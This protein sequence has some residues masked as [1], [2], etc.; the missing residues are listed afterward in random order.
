LKQSTKLIL[1]LLMAAVVPILVLKY[2]TAPL[3]AVTAYIVSALI[4]VAWVL[5]DL[6]LISRKFNYITTYVGLT[7][8]VR[9][10]LAFWFV[11]GW[12]FA[13]KDSAA[14]LVAVVTYGVSLLVGRPMMRYF[15]AQALSP[16]GPEQERSLAKLFAEPGVRRG[17]M[18]G[19]LAIALL[20]AIAGLGNY[21][22]NLYI[23]VA[24]FGGA[25]FNSQ[26]AKVNAITRIALMIPEL[27]GFVVAFLIV[28]RAL[29]KELPQE[30]GREQGESDFWDLVRL[31]EG[32]RA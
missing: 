11:D 8:I 6:L 10:A 30:P 18:L 20:N 13:F 31:R 5:V 28:M 4:P 24:P 1:D 14:Y 12:R 23:V 21:M 2:L 25:E 17:L 27:G 3:G 16:A 26:V 9:G 29:F 22:I 32:S 19:T 15:A 7:A